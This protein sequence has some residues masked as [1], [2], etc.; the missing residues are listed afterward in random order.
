VTASYQAT[1]SDSIIVATTAK[2]GLTVTLPSATGLVGKQYTIK[3]ADTSRA[4]V[5]V[6]AHGSQ[7]IDG[8][9]TQSLTAGYA[10]LTVVCDGSAWQV[11]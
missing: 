11:V 3:K 9:A 4:A 10:S 5:K 8:S 1:A 6:A 7:H 2:G